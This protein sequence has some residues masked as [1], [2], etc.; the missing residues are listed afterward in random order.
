MSH[1][2]WVRVVLRKYPEVTFTTVVEAKNRYNHNKSSLVY[3]VLLA[4]RE[5]LSGRMN[6]LSLN[7]IR[8]PIR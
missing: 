5:N 4:K 7:V 6:I 8:D 3:I 2:S 1:I